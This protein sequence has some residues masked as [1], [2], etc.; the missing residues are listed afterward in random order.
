MTLIPLIDRA[1]QV[2]AWADRRTGWISDM[3]GKIIA[4]IEQLGNGVFIAEAHARQIGWYDCDGV[5]RNRRGQV[6]LVQPNAKVDGLVI[7]RP[8][9][10]PAAP[11]A[12]APIGRPTLSWQLPLPMKQ[13]AW[14]D[15]ETLFDGPAQLRAFA[16]KVRS[17]MSRPPQTGRKKPTKNSA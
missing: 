14:A 6:V 15:F 8:Q 3:N 9:R 11:K 4:L 10:I 1:G 13:R 2:R 17:L 5:V 7:P 12:R 16:Q